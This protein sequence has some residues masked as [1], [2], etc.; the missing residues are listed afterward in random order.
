M[1]RGEAKAPTQRLLRVGEELRHALAA[2]FERGEIRDPGLAGI[3]VTVSEVRVT[4]DLRSAVVFVAPFGGGE[5]E[6]LLK[7]LSRARPYLRRRLAHLVQLKFTPDL[8]FR[9]DHSFEYASR[10]DALL[11]NADAGDGGGED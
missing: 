9:L 10:I 2:I 7:A 1:T 3:S 6:A 11:R 4:P 5:A 8:T